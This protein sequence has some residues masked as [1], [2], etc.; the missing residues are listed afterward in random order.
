MKI[1][2]RKKG[3]KCQVHDTFIVKQVGIKK[4]KALVPNAFFLSTPLLHKLNTVKRCCVHDGYLY[5]DVMCN[6]LLGTP[7][8]S[9]TPL[10]PLETAS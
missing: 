10:G 5:P 4:K 6:P 7:P 9:H 2:Q 1:K 8:S 3:E